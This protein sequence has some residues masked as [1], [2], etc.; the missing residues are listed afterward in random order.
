MIHVVLT[1]GTIDSHWDATTD[2]VMPNKKSVVPD[3]M[4]GLHLSQKI[5]YS[6]VCMKD[7]RAI[8]TADLK[9]M[10]QVIEKSPCHDVVVTHGTYTMADSARYVKAHLRRRDQTIIFTGSFVPLQGFTFS[11]APFNFGFSFAQFGHL[12]QGGV[13]VCMGGKI[14]TADEAIKIITKGKFVSLF[15]G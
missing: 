13:Y 5:K 9:K 8:T 3:Y 15:R 6:E 14:F 2:T 11:D 7:S 4:S 12:S 1:G 10:V